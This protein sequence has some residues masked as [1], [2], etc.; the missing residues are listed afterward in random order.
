MRQGP[1]D[2]CSGPASRSLSPRSR[3]PAAARPRAGEGE[4]VTATKSD[5]GYV[6]W[7]LFGRV[8]ER[9][10]YL[11]AEKGL[12]EPPLKQAWSINT[13]ALIEFPPAVH[14]GVAY[15]INKYGNG[16]AVRLQRPQGALGTEDPAQRQGQAELRHRAG[17]PRGLIYGA[18]L[19]GELAAGDAE[20]RQQSLG[21][22]APRPPR[23]LAAGGRRG[24]STSAPTRPTCVALRASDGKPRWRFNAPGGDQSQPQ[25]PRRPPLLRRLPELDVRARRRAAASRSGGPTRARCRHSAAAASSPP[26]PSASARSTRPATTAPSSPSTKRPA[27]SSG[28]STPAAPSTAPPPSPRSPAPRRPSTSAPKTAASSRSTP[29]PARSSG[30][31]TS[32]VRSPAPPS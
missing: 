22:R 19:D 9:T 24:R 14:D 12:L 31:A 11:P 29:P 8:P 5:A 27:R 3:S 16:K 28:P 4:G 30:G 32:A 2:A 20:D 7:P 6:D 13:H 21:A 18:F 10:H 26:P 1:D 17:L 23:I 25:P 15:V